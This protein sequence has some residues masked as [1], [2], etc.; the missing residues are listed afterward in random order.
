MVIKA[1]EKS[2]LSPKIEVRHVAIKGRGMFA[3][4]PI[5]AGETVII[6]GGGYTDHKGAEKGARAGKLV[7]QWDDDLF[8]VEDRAAEDAYFI[9]HSCDSNTWMQDAFTVVARKNIAVGEEVTADYAL[10]EHDES[11]VSDWDCHCGS[12]LCRKTHTGADWRLPELQKRYKNHF[13]P[14]LN[15]KIKNLQK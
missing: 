2:W 8:S 1:P 4:Q 12:K 11:H 15:K 14:F 6:W 9:N 7:M 5:K 3:T 10:W 13:T